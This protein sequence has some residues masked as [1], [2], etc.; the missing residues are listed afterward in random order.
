[1]VD[2]VSFCFCVVFFFVGYELAGIFMNVDVQF[3][4]GEFCVVWSGWLDLICCMS[5]KFK[6]RL[7]FNG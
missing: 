3:G 2:L 7:K 6:W 5:I 1:M 4:V